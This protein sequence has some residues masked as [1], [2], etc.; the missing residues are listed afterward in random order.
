M[1]DVNS[2]PDITK[3]HKSGFE[4]EMMEKKVAQFFKQLT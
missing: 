1:T 3:F 4:P 2:N